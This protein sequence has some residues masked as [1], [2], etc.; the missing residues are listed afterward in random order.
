MSETEDKPLL[1]AENDDVPSHPPPP[2]KPVASESDIEVP[3]AATPQVTYSKP[4]PLP[5]YAQSEKYETEGVL[6]FRHKDTDGE[7][8]EDEAP[9]R[10]AVTGTWCEFMLFFLVCSMLSV[11]GFV[12]AICVATT[13]ASQGGAV[14]GLGIALVSKPILFEMYDEQLV[15]SHVEVNYCSNA[16]SGSVD[17]CVNRV[18]SIARICFWL[19]GLFGIFLFYRGTATFLT[20]RR[21]NG[22]SR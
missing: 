21:A 18:Y 3:P 16:D 11:V 22:N 13:A 2:Y 12:F 19:I 9:L 15:R 17:T 1:T 20:A 8:T 6:D 4:M 10:V 14:A 7:D 5:T